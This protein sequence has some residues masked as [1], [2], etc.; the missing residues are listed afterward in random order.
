MKT[1]SK[2][3]WIAF[4]IIV[5]IY[6]SFFMLASSTYTSMFGAIF[7]SLLCIFLIHNFLKESLEEYGF[8]F[9]NIHIQIISGIALTFLIT[10]ILHYNAISNFISKNGF[11][12]SAGELMKRFAD[13]F[14]SYALFSLD[15]FDT[16]VHAIEEE[17]LYRGFILT[18]F[19]KAFHSSS[20]S[21]F[22]SALLFALAHLPFHQNW[23][24]VIFAFIFGI[25]Y[26]YLR[27]KDSEKFTIFSLCLAHFLQN[28]SLSFLLP[29]TN[30]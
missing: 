2:K 29:F 3:H 7:E 9:R 13:C 1:L 16:F 25:V 17:I 8:H 12:F 27:I 20:L 28:F 5:T 18:F 19:H 22:L 21:V 26:G 11:L 14:D 24:T 23:Y 10:F 30:F 15:L 6:I 4:F